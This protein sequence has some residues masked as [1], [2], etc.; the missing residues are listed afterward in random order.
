MTPAERDSLTDELARQAL[1]DAMC[2]SWDTAVAAVQAINDE[3]GTGAI[4]RACVAWMDTLIVHY[5]RATGHRDGD[6]VQPAWADAHTGEEWRDADQVDPAYRW[7]GRLIAA[8]A[9]MD[10]G[11]CDA[12]MMALPGDDQETGEHIKALLACV[13]LTLRSLLAGAS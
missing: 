13:A 11:A 4:E 3:C 10:H 1:E 8:R 5:Q 6:P 9:A 2:E 12:L 7:A